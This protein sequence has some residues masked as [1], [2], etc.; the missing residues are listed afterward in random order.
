MLLLAPGASVPWSRTAQ[1]T[2]PSIPQEP[3]LQQQGTAND[4]ATWM[5]KG[6]GG[7]DLSRAAAGASQ[8]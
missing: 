3:Q 5:G 4:A 6:K 2:A 7:C 8:P 1:A